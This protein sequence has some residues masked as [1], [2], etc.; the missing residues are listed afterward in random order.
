MLCISYVVNILKVCIRVACA[1]F[2]ELCGCRNTFC[3]MPLVS[4]CFCVCVSGKGLF[5]FFFAFLGLHLQH[6]EVPRLGDQ[7]EQEVHPAYATAQATWDPS[8]IC[9]LC[10]SLRQCR[11]LKPLSEA[12]DQTH[13][14]MG[15]SWVHYH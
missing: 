10:H 8:L 13:I 5:F 7:W 14:L 12:M 3:W 11:I 1:R 2:I 6:T 4:L 9:K 15:I